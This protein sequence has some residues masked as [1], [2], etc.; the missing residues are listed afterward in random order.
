MLQRK[1]SLW[2]VRLLVLSF[3]YLALPAGAQEAVEGRDYTVLR[4][5]QPTSAPDKIVVTEF[6]SYQCPH[7]FQLFPPIASWASKLPKDVVFERVAVGFG[8]SQW[9][10]M[11]QAFYALQALGQVD[12]LD[13]AIFNAIHTQGV[14]LSD[15]NS[16][17][18][19]VSKQGVD[20]KTFTSAYLSFGVRSSLA[21]SEQMVKSYKVE[22]VP[23]MVVDGKYVVVTAGIRNYDELLV[24]ADRVIAK[25]RAERGK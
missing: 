7:C 16:I 3:A 10:A 2:L 20:A 17:T 12:R 14:N 8:R 15:E 18:Q 6:F 21:R 23:S 11:A 4:P 24:R 5:A 13:S 1:F 22:G 9:T 25:V 19:W